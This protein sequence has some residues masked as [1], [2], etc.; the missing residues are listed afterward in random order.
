M[1]AALIMARA[2]SHDL[3]T[4]RRG[5]DRAALWLDRATIVFSVL[6]TL[7]ILGIMA[8]VV[9]DVIAR[10]AL[11][12]PLV[13]VPEIVSM[14][15]LAIVFLQLPNTVARGQ[16]TRSDMLVVRLAESAPRCGLWL[17]AICHLLGGVIVGTLVWALVPLF[18][19]TWTRN[20]MV[21]TMGQFLA[22]LWPVHG[23]VLLGSIMLCAVFLM[24]A[25]ALAILA[26]EKR[27]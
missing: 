12:R 6:G 7:G 19:R 8:L 4:G 17:D 27:L 2:T 1:V 16:L 26:E 18:I 13:G 22:P 20:E 14:S 10:G 5:F 25:A 3:L 23:I 15:I 24:R 9:S 21:G 11:N